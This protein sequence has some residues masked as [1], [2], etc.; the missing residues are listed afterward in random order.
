MERYYILKAL[1]IMDKDVMVM[2]GKNM[3]NRICIDWNA[4]DSNFLM[5]MLCSEWIISDDASDSDPPAQGTIFLMISANKRS[6]CS[7]WWFL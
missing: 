7:K 1:Y 2:K 4:G 3:Y 6:A 5:P